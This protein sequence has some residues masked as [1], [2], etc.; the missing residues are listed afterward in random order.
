MKA[1]KIDVKRG[2]Q[3][4]EQG[5]SNRAIAKALGCKA[6]AWRY[7]MRKAGLKPN[8]PTSEERKLSGKKPFLW[9]DMDFVDH[10]FPRNNQM[11]SISQ[12]NTEAR[13]L[14]MSYGQ[15]VAMLYCGALQRQKS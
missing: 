3:L 8:P 12:I 14:G 11:E 13:Q 10:T 5:M 2:F 15:Y 6:G 7:H 9:S 4:Y 1:A